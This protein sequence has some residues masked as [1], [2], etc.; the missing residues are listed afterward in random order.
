M[1]FFHQI[2]ILNLKAL[3]VLGL[4]YLLLLFASHQKLQLKAG[5]QLVTA[6]LWSVRGTLI[7][8]TAKRDH[9]IP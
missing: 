7:H 9:V 8:F 3:N 6:S 2:L 5:R 1:L 4:K